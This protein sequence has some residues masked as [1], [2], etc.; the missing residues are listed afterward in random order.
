[1]RRTN[2]SN[3]S[4][5]RITTTIKEEA[6]IFVGRNPKPYLSLSKLNDEALREKITILEKK[7]PEFKKTSGGSKKK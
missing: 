3:Q 1:M 7:Y 6:E 2:N 5:V 4:T